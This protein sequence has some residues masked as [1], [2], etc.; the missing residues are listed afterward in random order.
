MFVIGSKNMV[1]IAPWLDEFGSPKHSMT[2]GDY[3]EWNGSSK[4]ELADSVR[5]MVKKVKGDYKDISED[6]NKYDK[7]DFIRMAHIL[8]EELR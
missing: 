3:D 6:V 4:K 1:M 8:Q 7:D 5:N 2:I